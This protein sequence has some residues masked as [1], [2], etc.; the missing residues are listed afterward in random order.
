MKKLIFTFLL[1]F[2]CLF[3]YSQNNKL[4]FPNDKSAYGWQH[5]NKIDNNI[6]VGIV[7]SNDANKL[8]NY[9]YDIYM[10]SDTYVDSTVVNVVVGEIVIEFFSIVQYIEKT[11]NKSFF[12][13]NEK[14]KEDIQNNMSYEKNKTYEKP[15]EYKLQTMVVTDDPILI[16]SVFIPEQNAEIIVS[17]DYIKKLKN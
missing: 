8:G 12:I 11:E 5:S 1:I 13:S 14:Y 16:Y 6:W 4:L 2:T 9:R 17:W 3:G 15:D 10:T 7:I